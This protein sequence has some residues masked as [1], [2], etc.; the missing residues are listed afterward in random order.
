MKFF[1]LAGKSLPPVNALSF[2]QHGANRDVRR[3]VSG[4]RQGL[5]PVGADYRQHG[6]RSWSPCLISLA[7]PWS[8]MSSAS[9][10]MM[11]RRR[12]G[13]S[14]SSRGGRSASSRCF[15]LLTSPRS[16]LL[17]QLSAGSRWSRYFLLHA[18]SL[19]TVAIFHIGKQT[20]LL[21][22]RMSGLPG[23]GL[24]AP[25]AIDDGDRPL[26]TPLEVPSFH[27]ATLAA[28]TR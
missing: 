15:I 4:A 24:G 1:F 6:V 25:M 11:D 23:T 17:L 10:R 22:P 2:V 21:V 19:G 26:T 12:D 28:C 14:F 5:E 13:E 16:G 8:L 18:Q 27:Q 9:R 3:K 7:K 20:G